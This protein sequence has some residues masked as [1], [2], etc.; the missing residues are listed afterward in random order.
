MP[1]RRL[2]AE[3]EPQSAVQLTFPHKDTD[4]AEVLD[5]VLPC[6]IQIAETIS[7]FQ[8]VLVVCSD[9]AKTRESLKGGNSRNFK[10]V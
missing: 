7:R 2:P 8:P 10:F 6:F 5:T 1:M 4:W 3:W 9:V